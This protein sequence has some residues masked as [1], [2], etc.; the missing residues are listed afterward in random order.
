MSINGVR[1]QAGS[2]FA[3][4]GEKYKPQHFIYLTIPQVGIEHL[5]FILKPAGCSIPGQRSSPRLALPSVL[6]SCIGNSAYTWARV[7]ALYPVVPSSYNE[8][9]ASRLDLAGKWIVFFGIVFGIYTALPFLAPLFMHLGWKPVGN[10]IYFIYSFLCH[11]LPERS[12]FL[13]G[14]KLT[15]SLPDI[16]AAW[17]TTIHP[18]VLRQFIGNPQMGWKVAWSD[19]MVSMFT[20]ILIFGLSWWPLRRRL[21]PLPLWGLVL[22][23]L[24]MVMDGTT[25]FISDLA[26]IGNGF[27]DTNFWLV[28]MT[29]NSFP[30]TFY[31]GDAWGSFNSIMRLLSGILFGLGI[32]WFGF[33]YL[34]ASINDEAYERQA[35]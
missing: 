18:M 21:K 28:N 17:Q 31:A 8:T 5:T 11:Q 32:V 20:A 24:P 27:R 30:S 14:Q 6:L 33:P 7:I 13:F 23:V 25:H 1:H 10:A 4:T 26:G 3:E 9:M 15:Y 12:F 22:L 2:A 35:A 16:Q 19:R 29:Q 34:N